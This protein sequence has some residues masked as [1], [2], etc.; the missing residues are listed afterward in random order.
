MIC[1]Q[2]KETIPQNF[3]FEKFEF[4]LLIGQIV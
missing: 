3:C 4:F 1:D 2:L